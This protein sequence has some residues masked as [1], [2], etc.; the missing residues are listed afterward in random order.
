MS[1]GVDLLEGKWWTK[2]TMNKINEVFE[3]KMKD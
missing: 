3:E 2:D 1:K